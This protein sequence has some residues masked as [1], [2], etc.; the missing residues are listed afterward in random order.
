FVTIFFIYIKDSLLYERLTAGGSDLSTGRL[1][2][3]IDAFEIFTYY[4]LFGASD[5]GY[6]IEMLKRFSY[7]MDT[8]NLFLL[9]LVKVGLI[10]FSIFLFLFFRMIKSS[11]S[12]YLKKRDALPLMLFLAMFIISFK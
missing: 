6:R 11:I 4:P 2:I 12:Y 1:D 9:F 10:C 7:Y 3:W 5:P 8:H